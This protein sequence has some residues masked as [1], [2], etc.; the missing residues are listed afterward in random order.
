MYLSKTE[1]IIVVIAAGFILIGFAITTIQ[2]IRQSIAEEKQ[3][4]EEKKKNEDKI[5]T[6][7]K[8]MDFKKDYLK[9]KKGKEK[10]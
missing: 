2:N 5:R 7:I 3:K 1:E 6:L 9:K 4:N 10:I 8:Y